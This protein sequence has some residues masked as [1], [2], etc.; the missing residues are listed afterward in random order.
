MEWLLNET[1]SYRNYLIT[2]GASILENLGDEKLSETEFVKRFIHKKNKPGTPCVNLDGKPARFI[3]RVLKAANMI[4][5]DQNGICCTLEAIDKFGGKEK[6]D[7]K[8]A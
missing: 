8:N 7:L 5:V 3:L 4:Y 2:T 1:S 6:H